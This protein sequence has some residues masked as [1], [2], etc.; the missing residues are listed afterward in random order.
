MTKLSPIIGE[1]RESDQNEVPDMSD[2]TN[3]GKKPRSIS[4][5][6]ALALTSAVLLV[7]AVTIAVLYLNAV[8]EQ[9]SELTGK[10]GEYSQYLAGALEVPLWMYDDNTISAICKTFSQNELVVS[11]EIRDPA[12]TVVHTIKKN[13]ESDTLASTSKVYH[14]GELLGEIKLTVTRRFAAEAGRKLLAPF[15]TITLIVAIVLVILSNLLVRLFLGK[16]IEALE[17]IAKP[18]AGGIYDTPVQE[19]PWLEF[20]TFGTTLALMGETIKTQM[21]E[22]RTHRDHLEEMVRQRTQELTAAKEQAEKANRAKSVF[23]ANMS[24]E[25]RTPLNAVLGFSQLMRN[26]PEATGEQRKN[27]EIITN[28]GAHLLNL[29]NNVLDISKIESGRVE[30]EEAPLD[31]YQLL[32]E[33][34]SLMNVREAEKDLIFSAKQSADLP[35]FVAIDG[36]KLRQVLINLTGNAI[37]YTA[38]GS[39]SIRASASET[40]QPDRPR[41]RFEIAD[42]GP[43]IAE[44]DR[45][46][47]FL[48]F[49]QLANQPL[50][51]TGTGLGLAISK[52][53]VELMGG[54]IDVDSE[55]GKGSVFYF[56]IPAA[57][58]PADKQPAVTQRGR[59][60]GLAEGQGSYR[61]LIAEDQPENRLLLRKLL[62]SLGF[63]VREAENGEEAVAICEDWRPNLIFMDIRMPVMDGLEAT[64]RIKSSDT[65]A[66]TRIVAVT[67]H[68]LE[69]EQREILAAGCDYLIRKPYGFDDIFD[70]LTKNIGARFVYEEEA[71]PAVA[72]A[73]LD[74]AALAGL[75]QELLSRLEQALI[76][77]DIAAVDR[78]IEE[79]RTCNDPLADALAPLARD[80]EFGRILRL[81]RDAH[82]K[83]KIKDET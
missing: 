23:L 26:D 71:A 1:C 66:Q 55:P 7:S 75:P 2:S 56:E 5:R 21:A 51:G 43:G 78:A 72:L 19:L 33:M 83:N 65:G 70:A 60:T 49:V 11:L 6:F 46:R 40:G 10:A 73:E 36:G 68:A 62:E 47:I 37:K 61:L 35:R 32:Q 69:E 42:C 14:Q 57:L 53:Y 59:C 74:A 82:G 20:Q 50:A 8:R 76:R 12:G 64:R 31:L 79:I 38:G 9:E 48:P 22:L 34:Q 39:V 17:R 52:Q 54:L 28:S 4:R 58:P 45:K 80:S 41:L 44:A 24:H 15:A 30:L 67:A 81:V 63:A 18:Y 77:I 13:N 16:P 25:L 27:L 29:I 3:N